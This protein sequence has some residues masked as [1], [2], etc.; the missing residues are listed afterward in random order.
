MFDSLWTCAHLTLAI[1]MDIEFQVG[2]VKTHVMYVTILF[3]C[4]PPP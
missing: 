2:S 1:K 3:Q 4:T